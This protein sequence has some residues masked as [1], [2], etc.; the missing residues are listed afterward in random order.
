M[1][2]ATATQTSTETRQSEM[3][4]LSLLRWTWADYTDFQEEVYRSFIRHRFG[5]C[6]VLCELYETARIFREEFV[7]AWEKRDARF[8]SRLNQENLI[9][10]S[11][12]LDRHV[13]Y[14]LIEEL[15]DMYRGYHSHET[16]EHCPSYSTRRLLSEQLHDT[17]TEE[18]FRN[19]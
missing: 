18:Y 15:R 7:W 16:I 12:E 14:E 13:H 9:D 8:V 6:E 10:G 19:R 3:L 2:T 17:I 4:L 5:H 11:L 1:N